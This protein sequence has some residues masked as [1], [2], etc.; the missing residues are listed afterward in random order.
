MAEY[1]ASKLKSPDGDVFII[2]DETARAA[3]NDKVDISQG[4]AQ[5]GK[6]LKVNSSGN[7]TLFD[8]PAELPQVSN[9]DNGDILRVVNGA[10]A[11]ATLPSANGGSF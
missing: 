2:K 7:L 4:M 3:L 1:T 6:I 8:S 11:K 5:A 9:F 10:W